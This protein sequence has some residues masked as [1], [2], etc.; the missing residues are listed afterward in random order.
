MRKKLIIFALPLAMTLLAGCNKGE[1]KFKNLTFKEQL[2]V[3]EAAKVIGKAIKEVENFSKL[4]PRLN[5][6]QI[7]TRQSS[8]ENRAVL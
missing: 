6:I 7:K 1:T 5:L 8:K 4:L 3:G 2:T